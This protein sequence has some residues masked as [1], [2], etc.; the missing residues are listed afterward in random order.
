[1]KTKKNM[2]QFLALLVCLSLAIPA[3]I[4]PSHPVYIDPKTGETIDDALDTDPGITPDSI[5]YGFERWWEDI[6]V[7]TADTKEEQAALLQSLMQERYA[8]FHQ[9]IEQG[10]PGISEH[11]VSEFAELEESLAEIVEGIEPTEENLD[12]LH[13]IEETALEQENIREM[14]EQNMENLVAAGEL[15]EEQAENLADGLQ[16]EITDVQAAVEA[17]EEEIADAIAEEQGITHLEAEFQVEAAEEEAGLAEQHRGEVEE[18]LAEVQQQLEQVQADLAQA[19]AEGIDVPPVATELLAEAQARLDEC[20]NA[21]ADG[22]F[23]ESFGQF[24]AAEHLLDNA[25]RFLEGEVSREE[26][27][28]VVESTQEQRIENEQEYVDEY[29]ENVDDWSDEFPEYEDDFE[30]W[31]EQG[32]KAIELDGA[33]SDTYVAQQA[34]QMRAEGRT[35]QEIFETLGAQFRSEYERLY[36]ETFVPPVFGV[37]GE[38]AFP[39]PLFTGGVD[40]G[41]VYDP[42][43][44]PGGI[45][46]PKLKDFSD[47]P[48]DG[49]NTK[50]GFVEGYVYTDP[51][52]GYKYEFTEKGYTY[53]TPLGLV[54][55]ETFPEGF[56]VPP[57]Y[58]QGNEKHSY[59]TETPEGPVTYNYYATGYDG[60]LADGTTETYAYPEGGYNVVGGGF[61]EHSATGFDFRYGGEL[62]HYDYNPVYDTFIG[63]EGAVYRPPEGT[64][65]HGEEFNYDYDNQ[66]YGYED[67]EGEAWTYNPETNTWTS[68]TGETHS[69]DAYTVAPVGHEG[70]GE[71]ST[72]TGEVWSWDE[73]TGTWSNTGGDKYQPGTGNWESGIGKTYEFD[74]STGQFLDPETGDVARDVV[75]SGVTWY[76]DTEAN[77]WTSNTGEVYDGVGGIATPPGG[78]GHPGDFEDS[79]DWS[80]DASTGTWT[81]PGWNFDAAT[82][83]WSS[84]DGGSF[85]DPDGNPT[86][87][88]SEDGSFQSWDS[89]GPVE[90]YAAP[91]DEGSYAGSYDG[92]YSGDYSGT[93]TGDYSGGYVGGYE[94][95]SYSGGGYTG[96]H[97]AGSY[98]GGDSGGSYSGGDS[99]GSAPSGDGGGG[100]DGGDGGGGDGG[101]DGG[102][103]GMA[104]AKSYTAKEL[105]P[106]TRWIYKYL[107]IKE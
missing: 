22:R 51:V 77:S 41:S 79:V 6:Q 1:M 54:Y 106:V 105:H 82:G 99:G 17:Q 10:E 102:G 68:P 56:S 9:M 58:E 33:L 83:E 38:H 84:P 2:M 29:E 78:G 65:F 107:G 3:V 73:A 31:Y 47:F 14:L 48:A 98:S 49:V 97:D 28:E 95:G 26:L 43:L 81:A 4:A 15:S 39:D 8:E 36:G 80:Y 13:E 93:Y 57:A 69:P 92:S 101:G 61:F 21:L 71:Y 32:Q 52:T 35:E 103:S 11:I 60:T 55:E 44:E 91:E 7:A 72:D 66:W 45:Y 37:D 100:H 86:G 64:Y 30:D 88:Y 63:A 42:R 40:D 74:H 89:V 70:E 19:V 76:F 23:G 53:T 62:N 94:G 85:Y 104:V 46:G 75:W 5:W 59:T 20:Q 67:D 12:F 18:E 50:G 16:E 34:D 27:I 90:R 25:E 24:T 96:G 87:Y